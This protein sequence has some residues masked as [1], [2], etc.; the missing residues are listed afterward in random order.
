MLEKIFNNWA[1]R[2]QN[3]F[4]STTKTRTIKRNN[5]SRASRLPSLFLLLSCTIDVILSDIAHIFQIWS[6]LAGY[7]EFSGEFEPSRNKE[8]SFLNE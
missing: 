4:S 6:M 1:V 2:E 7:E 3:V 5:I 8:V